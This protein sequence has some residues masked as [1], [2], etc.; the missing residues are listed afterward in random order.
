MSHTN[1]LYHLIFATKNRAPIIHTEWESSLHVYLGGIIKG[2]NGVPIE[3]NGI[4][5]HV[6]A[7]VRLSPTKALAEFLREFKSDSTGF[8]RREF[9]K[10]FSWQRRYGAFTVSESN[11]ETVRAYIRNQ[12]NHHMT[13]G[14][15]EEY[16]KI[17]LLNSVE[18]EEKYLWN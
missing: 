11:V 7:L 13:M 8:V 14:F 5:D 6:H 9:E 15:D 2:Q 3:I 10:R 17:L 12:K 4:E 18:F 1:L 16:R